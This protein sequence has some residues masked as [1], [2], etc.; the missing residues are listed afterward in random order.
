MEVNKLLFR[1]S[2]LKFNADDLGMFRVKYIKRYKDLL[3]RMARCEGAM[4]GAA[5][6]FYIPLL[7]IVTG[8]NEYFFGHKAIAKK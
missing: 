5:Y 6:W 2:N 3:F 1:N 8:A 7:C 4:R